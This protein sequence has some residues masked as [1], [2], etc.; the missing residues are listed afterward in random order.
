M[1][2]KTDG[3]KEKNSNQTT[4]EGECVVYIDLGNFYYR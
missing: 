2:K 4:K 3:I 1:I